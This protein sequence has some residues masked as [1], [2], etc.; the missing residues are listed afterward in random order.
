MGLTTDW[1]LPYPECAPPLRKDAADIA[2]VRDLAVAMDEDV[3]SLYDD[4]YDLLI[5]PGACRMQTSGT[6]TSGAGQIAFRPFYDVFNFD[7]SPLSDPMQDTVNGL[8]QIREPGVYLCGTWCSTVF[9]TN[10]GMRVKFLK[11][12]VLAANPH[13]T[14]NIISANTAYMS[15]TQTLRYQQPGTLATELTAQAGTTWAVTSRIW[16]FQLVKF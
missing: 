3:Q 13:G 14:S 11:D 9:A 8:I 12:G 4:A 1:G 2:Q 10:Q 7:N 16:A 5:R 15:A 6:Q